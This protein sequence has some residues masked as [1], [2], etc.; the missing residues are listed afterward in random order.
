[1]VQGYMSNFFRSVYIYVH[2]LGLNLDMEQT[3]KVYC[4]YTLG[5]QHSFLLWISCRT[6]GA[7]VARKP[8]LVLFSSL[9]IVLVLCLGLIRLRVETRPEK[10]CF[11]VVST[12]TCFRLFPFCFLMCW[13]L[14]YM[15]ISALGWTWQQ[16]CKR[17][18][19][20][21]HPPGTFL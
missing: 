4:V 3:V 10:V 15:L 14:T 11:C 1:M 12:L 16:G 6:Y 8:V 18:A 5:L 7:W 13:I 2:Q 20:F 21:R 17:E 9:A 19:F